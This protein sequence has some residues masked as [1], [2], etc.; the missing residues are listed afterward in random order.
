ML[1][2]KTE[3]IINNID[4]IDNVQGI[5]N[6]FAEKYFDLYNSVSYDVDNMF[7]ETVENEIYVLVE[8]IYVQ[9]ITIFLLK[10]LCLL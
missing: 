6:L 5:A 10:T 4:G 8:I 1:V 3:N 7:K 9:V 2:E